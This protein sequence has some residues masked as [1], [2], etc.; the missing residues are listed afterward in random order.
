MILSLMIKTVFHV[1]MYSLVALS[2][3]AF[4]FVLLVFHFVV[5]SFFGSTVF[6][7]VAILLFAKVTHFTL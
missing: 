1:A 4:A 6:C 2:A 5:L 7:L 3:L